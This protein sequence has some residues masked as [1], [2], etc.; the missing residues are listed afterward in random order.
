MYQGRRKT[1]SELIDKTK[2]KVNQAVG[3]LTG[4]ERRKREDEGDE[5][6]AK[7]KAR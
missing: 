4:N 5:T 1:I 6:K 3:D 7:S 2:G